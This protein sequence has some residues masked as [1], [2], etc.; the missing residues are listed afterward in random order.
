MTDFFGEMELCL[1]VLIL[2]KGFMF[3][4][5]RKAGV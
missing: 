1:T 2:M 3:A 5:N 4:M